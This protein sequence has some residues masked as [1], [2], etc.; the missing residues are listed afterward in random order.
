VLTSEI[1]ALNILLIESVWREYRDECVL[2]LLLLISIMIFSWEEIILE[3]RYDIQIF[4]KW[5]Q[6]GYLKES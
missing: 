2:T 5:T 1:I 4:C 6:I 3:V